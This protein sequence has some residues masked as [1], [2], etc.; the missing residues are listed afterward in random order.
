[1]TVHGSHS[2]V[3]DRSEVTLGALAGPLPPGSLEP[4]PGLGG[5]A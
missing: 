1:M 5:P 3:A 2:I 4:S